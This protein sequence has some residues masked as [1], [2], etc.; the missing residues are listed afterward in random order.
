MKKNEL[1]S[2]VTKL[3]AAY[4]RISRRVGALPDKKGYLT[5]MLGI[6]EIRVKQLLEMSPDELEKVAKEATPIF[7]LTLPDLENISQQFNKDNSE[8]AASLLRAACLISNCSE[9]GGDLR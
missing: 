6:D 9:E 4:L 1:D 7:R 8:K 2:A 3:T 5:T